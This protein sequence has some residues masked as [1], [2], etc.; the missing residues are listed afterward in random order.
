MHHL[1]SLP[2]DCQVENYVTAFIVCAAAIFIN[3]RP[4]Q[5]IMIVCLDGTP[6]SG[7]NT[8]GK[9]IGE[10]YG[11]SF[12]SMGDL[13]RSIAKRKGIT[14]VDLNK[15]RDKSGN[16]DKDID[17][18]ME[19]LGKEE[20]NFIITSRTSHHFIPHGIKIFLK[21]NYEEAAN[22]IW[23]DLQESNERNEGSFGTKEDLLKGLKERQEGDRKR[24]LKYYKIDV[25][26]V[27]SYDFVLETAGLTLKQVF[28]IVDTYVAQKKAH[29]EGATAGSE[30]AEDTTEADDQSEEAA[31]QDIQEREEEK[32]E[33][34]TKRR[35]TETPEETTIDFT[36]SK[37]D[38]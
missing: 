30:E 17:T 22:R 26:D 3:E 12:Y 21:T 28:K 27:Q 37:Q 5:Q 35:E 14:L 31:E 16:I 32:E 29:I 15:L 13:M 33:A 19:E 36:P 25:N 6:G 18:Y 24:Y 7:K 2:S 9:M 34:E 1:A 38:E 10:K 11:L 20:D 23:K 4:K 8:I